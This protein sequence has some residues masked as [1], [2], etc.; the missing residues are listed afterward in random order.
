[1]APVLVGD[2]ISPVKFHTKVSSHSSFRFGAENCVLVLLHPCING[3][4]WSS[5]CGRDDPKPVFFQLVAEA[6]VKLRLIV[7]NPF[8]EQGLV[9]VG[10]YFDWV[11]GDKDG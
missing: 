2:F 10:C 11:V 1:M 8:F 9:V 6:I 7:F 3:T 5:V 4:A